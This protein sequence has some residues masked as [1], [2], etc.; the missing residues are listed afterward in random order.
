MKNFIKRLL[1]NMTGADDTM[2]ISILL[3]LHRNVQGK[4]GVVRKGALEYRVL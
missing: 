3:P 2:G 4:H 1:G